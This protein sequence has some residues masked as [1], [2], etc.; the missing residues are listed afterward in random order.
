MR[1][2]LF[3]FSISILLIS[4]ACSK[5]P[6]SEARVEIIDG[7]EHVHNTGTPLHPDKSVTFEEELSI[8]GEEYDMLFRPQRFIVDQNENIY[9][10]DYQDQ[11]IKVFDPKG[12][13]I[14]TIGKK[15][16]GP[17]EFTFVGHLTVL[18]DGRLLVMDSEARRISLFDSDGKYMESHH[19][20]ERPG[21]LNYATDST[22]LLTVYTFEGDKP[23]EGRRLFVKEFDFQGNEIRSFGEFKIEE[24][25]MHTERRG[26]TVIS[27]V[28]YAP[29]SPHSIFAADPMRQYLYHCVNNEYMIEVF[30]DSGKAIRRFDRPYEPLPFTSR[31]AEEFYSRYDSRPMEGLKKMVQGMSMPA[32]KTITPKMLVDDVGNLWV[33]TYEQREEEDKVFAAYDI[34]NPDGYYEAKV[35]IDLKPEIFVKGKMYRMHRDEKTGYSLVKR[36]RV[37]WNG[38]N[39]GT[40]TELAVFGKTSTFSRI[41]RY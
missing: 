26:E 18:P 39:S 34:F 22:C 9:I 2:T 25:K 40:G 13:Y 41:R 10:T 12:E 31:D 16:E 20:T 28:I 24:S 17:G 19:W 15:G 38:H 8:G 36:Y 11:S 32:V 35:W 6:E 3:V 21:R 37:V 4:F 14:R 29:H 5:K 30:D 33:E 27:M 1:R 7:V 23:L